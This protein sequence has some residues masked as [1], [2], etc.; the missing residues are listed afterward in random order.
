MSGTVFVDTNI[1]I[2]ALDDGDPGKR[3]AARGWRAHLWK[4]RGGRIS[5]QV[6]E[7]FYSKT[8]RRR[9]DTRDQVRSEIRDL[10]AWNPVAIDVNL[11]ESAWKVQDRYGFSFWD[12]MIVAAARSSSCRYLLTEDLQPDQNIDEVTVVNPFLRSPTE[13]AFR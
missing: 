13:S 2:Y 7:E 5:F 4:S 10:M 11:I 3:D 8:T 9:P 1:L 12:A 6:L